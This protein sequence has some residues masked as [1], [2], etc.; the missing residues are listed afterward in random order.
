MSVS[1]TSSQ[2]SSNQN[3]TVD[4][5]VIS[6]RLARKRTLDRKAQQAARSRTKW[7]IENLQYQVAQ[8]NNALI[9]ETSRL[10]ALLQESKDE[11]ERVNAENQTLRI[12]LQDAMS[13]EPGMSSEDIEVSATD[14]RLW[15][16]DTG[17][18]AIR[19]SGSRSVSVAST[20]LQ[21]YESIPWNTE[22]TCVS[23][24]ILQSYAAAA[25]MRVH[26][27]SDIFLKDQPDMTALLA[28]ERSTDNPGVSNVVSDILLAYQEINTLPKKA[29]CL[30]V[31]YKLLNVSIL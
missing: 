11:T 15:D 19:M 10:Q 18:V 30:Y 9:S 22:P 1:S 13:R 6:D 17:D 29:A 2:T 12:Q 4:E 14:P 31:M 3:P 24:R 7:T 20:I 26:A 21:P 16:E 28:Q 25:R 5:K 27:T 8:L 23:D